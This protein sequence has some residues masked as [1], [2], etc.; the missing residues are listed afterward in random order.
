M[1]PWRKLGLNNGG[2]LGREGIRKQARMERP[3][4]EISRGKTNEAGPQDWE[5]EA[6]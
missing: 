3:E 5:S 2:Q 4:A 6:Q 1:S